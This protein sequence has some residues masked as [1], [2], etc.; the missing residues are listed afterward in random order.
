MGDLLKS[1][2]KDLDYTHSQRALCWRG[3]LSYV[4]FHPKSEATTAQ[5]RAPG[6]VI[7]VV[8]MSKVGGGTGGEKGVFLGVISPPYRNA[9][10]HF[11]A[12]ACIL[13]DVRKDPIKML[14]NS[15]PEKAL[16]DLNGL[17]SSLPE[18]AG[19]GIKDVAGV[20]TFFNQPSKKRFDVVER[21]VIN[22]AKRAVQGIL[23][24]QRKDSKQRIEACYVPILQWYK[25][26]QIKLYRPLNDTVTYFPDD[27]ASST[28]IVLQVSI[29]VMHI[30][31]VHK[32][33]LHTICAVHKL[34]A[35]LHKMYA[36]HKFCVMWHG[37]GSIDGGV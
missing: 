34:Y 30:H 5:Q 18:F 26:N 29:A 36:L 25:A 9:S 13:V 11:K 32:L 12:N 27:K 6:V 21:A 15:I 20:A 4:E 33:L 23:P 7:K 2:K 16:K 35:I 19:L 3:A 24:A 8:D 31:S 22:S 14:T 1:K 17:I 10:G 28:K 37:C